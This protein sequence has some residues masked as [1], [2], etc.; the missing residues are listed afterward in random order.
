ML[1]LC[2]VDE[3]D[4]MAALVAELQGPTAEDAYRSVL[5]GDGPKQL[6]ACIEEGHADHVFGVPLF[7]LRGELF[8]GNDRVPMLEARLAEYGLVR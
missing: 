3:P 4:Q 2:A 6:E 7:V 8:W 5:A 1:A